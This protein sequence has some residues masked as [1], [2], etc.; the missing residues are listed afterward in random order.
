MAYYHHVSTI[1]PPAGDD[2]PSVEE[3]IEKFEEEIGQ[4]V[5]AE[6][7]AEQMMRASLI[8]RGID[9]DAKPEISPELAAKLEEDAMK[10]DKDIFFGN[11]DREFKGKKIDTEH[12]FE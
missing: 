8:A 10:S 11:M 6:S 7:K 12:D 1:Q 5:S 2:D 9:P 3:Q 4:R